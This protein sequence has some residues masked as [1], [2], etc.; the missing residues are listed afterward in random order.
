[1][2]R[3]DEKCIQNSVRNLEGKRSLRRTRCRW[4]SNIMMDLRE[5]W[6]EGVDWM[7]LAQHRD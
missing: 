5:I 3:R 4:E 2:H 7:L 1:M 6:W